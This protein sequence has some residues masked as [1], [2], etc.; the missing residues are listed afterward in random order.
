MK[1][2]LSLVAITLFVSCNQSTNSNS[3]DRTY[4]ENIGIDRSTAAGERLYQAYSALKNNCMSCLSGYH[5]AWSS[6]NTDQAWINS[7]LVE[8][9]DAYGSTLV[10]RL[11]NI[12][13]NMPKDNPQRSEEDFDKIIEWI[14]SI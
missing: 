9:N 5:N 6:Y 8:S 11:K 12:G 10:I 1:I 2:C 7:G 13:G 4:S 14:D 3:F